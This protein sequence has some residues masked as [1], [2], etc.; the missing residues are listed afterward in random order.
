MLLVTIEGVKTTVDLAQIPQFHSFIRR[1][2]SNNPFIERI[3][4]QTVNLTRSNVTKSLLE[5]I[6]R[7]HSSSFKT[8]GHY[9]KT[10]NSIKSKDKEKLKHNREEHYKVSRLRSMYNCQ[11]GVMPRVRN[12]CILCIEFS[13]ITPIKP[14][15]HSIQC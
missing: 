3:E 9:Q 11:S 10:V 13:I 14:L 2:S 4:S 7:R 1:T 12:L 8:P 15:S 6:L 5:V